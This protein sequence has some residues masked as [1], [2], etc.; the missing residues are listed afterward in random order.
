MAPLEMMAEE[1]ILGWL[2][3]DLG[4]KFLGFTICFWDKKGCVGL[5]GDG[6]SL[7]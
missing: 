6:Q 3:Q 2:C 7:L 5:L 1:I 4:G